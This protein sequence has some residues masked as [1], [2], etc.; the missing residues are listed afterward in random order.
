MLILHLIYANIH[1]TLICIFL[2]K[3]IFVRLWNCDDHLYSIQLQ[4]SINKKNSVSKNFVDFIFKNAR[5]YSHK[6]NESICPTTHYF[7]LWTMKWYY[8]SMCR[9]FL[10]TN[11][12]CVAQ[13][14]VTLCAENHIMQRMCFCRNIQWQQS[15]LFA[16]WILTG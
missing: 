16:A 6:S 8:R 13:V 15:N 7:K 10:S 9:T 4:L 11:T 14:D 5:R 1:E 2:Y 3:T 12:T